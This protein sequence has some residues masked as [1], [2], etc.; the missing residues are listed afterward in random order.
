MS[1]TQIWKPS[2]HSCFI[3]L[4]ILPWPR[5]FFWPIGCYMNKRSFYYYDLYYQMWTIN[6]TEIIIMVSRKSISFTQQVITVVLQRQKRKTQSHQLNISCDEQYLI[7]LCFWEAMM[8]SEHTFE[9][10][11]CFGAFPWFQSTL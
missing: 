2:L 4:G 1:C 5:W 8:H 10:P 7:F 11:H 3:K 9:L 6:F